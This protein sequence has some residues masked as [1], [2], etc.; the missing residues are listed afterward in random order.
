MNSVVGWNVYLYFPTRN[1]FPSV[2][3]YTNQTCNE[4][5]SDLPYRELME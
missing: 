3:T 5:L 4:T 2:Y 1:E